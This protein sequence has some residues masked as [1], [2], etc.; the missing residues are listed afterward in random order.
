MRST[1]LDETMAILGKHSIRATY[2]ARVEIVALEKERDELRAALCDLL[3]SP[4]LNL[5][6]LE[7]ETVAMIA[8]ARAT[9][10]KGR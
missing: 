4:D 8:S 3:D 9:L 10:A 6:E 5:D 7:S 2:H 1:G